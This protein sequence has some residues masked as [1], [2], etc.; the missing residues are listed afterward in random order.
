[1]DIIRIGDKVVS[2]EKLHARIEEILTLRSQGAT[3]EE[4]AHVAHVPRTFV[5]HVETLGAVRRGGRI[6]FIAFPISNPQDSLAL[7]QR[8]GVELAIAFSQDERLKIEDSSSA[9]M[10]NRM[11]DTLAALKS[12]DTVVIAASD[13]RIATFRAA[14]DAEVVGIVLGASPIK[15]DCELNLEELEAV[16]KLLVQEEG[17]RS[18]LTGGEGAFDL[19]KRWL[20]LKR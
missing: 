10:F 16:F 11:I 2:Q 6:G 8:Y 12:Y 4:A 14:L 3:Q 15:E 20:S 5:S 1:M 19:A 18:S 9:D 7:A 13:Y 17:G